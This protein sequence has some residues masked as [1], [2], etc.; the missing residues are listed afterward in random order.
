VAEVPGPAGYPRNTRSI[1]AVVRAGPPLLARSKQAAD[2]AATLD[3][4]WTG[5]QP[6]GGCSTHCL[7]ETHVGSNTPS[8]P[9]D[10]A[11]PGHSPCGVHAR[12]ARKT[13]TPVPRSEIPPPAAALAA[14]SIVRVGS[15]FLTIGSGGG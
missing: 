9:G 2:R 5:S 7:R 3:R 12:H 4:L 10:V 13:S 1:T 6:C 14:S 11:L 15:R 8:N